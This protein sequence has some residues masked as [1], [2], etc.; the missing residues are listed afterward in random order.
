MRAS[1]T[2]VLTASVVTVVVAAVVGGF[3][4]I[5]SPSH[6]RMRRLD[7][8]RVADLRRIAAALDEY[9]TRHGTLPSSLETLK[10]KRGVAIETVD[11]ATGRP[12]QY[13]AG[14]RG[15]YSLCADFSA[16]STREQAV[17]SESFWVHGSGQYCFKL[18]AR[19]LKR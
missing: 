15:E 2:T 9:W 18:H 12:Y 1:G 7:I 8:R 4:L 6:E 14:S 10:Q 11:P 3:V 13:R 5:G 19:N 16:S 17:P